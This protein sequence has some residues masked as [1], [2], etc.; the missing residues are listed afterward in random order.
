MEHILIENTEMH[1]G[2]LSCKGKLVLIYTNEKPTTGG[3]LIYYN[4]ETKPHFYYDDKALALCVFTGD[5][6]NWRKCLP[7]I[8]SETENPKVKDL[9]AVKLY[10]IKSE[11]MGFNLEKCTIIE[12]VW[13]NNYDVV[14]Q[15]HID[16]CKKALALPEQFSKEQLES[17][18]DGRIKNGDE[19]FL[20]CEKF[21]LPPNKDMFEVKLKDGFVNIVFNESVPH[22]Q[23]TE[24][25]ASGFHISD[26]GDPSVGMFPSYWTLDGDFYFDGNEELEQFKKKLAEAF[27]Y[28]TDGKLIIETLEDHQ[29]AIKLEQELPDTFE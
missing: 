13:I 22:A 10:N 28:A 7:V 2:I 23:P 3:E 27:E 21:G 4:G 18:V 11:D 29:F 16:N 19:I 24:I 6:G 8:V 1:D 9:Y 25:K 15:R 5:S 17:I 20:L 14:Q 26:P 12:D